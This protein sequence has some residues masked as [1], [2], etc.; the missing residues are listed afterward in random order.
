MDEGGGGGRGFKL[1]EREV[2]R[3]GVDRLGGGAGCGVG[4]PPQ[5]K[6]RSRLCVGLPPPPPAPL[7]GAPRPQ[8][9]DKR[10]F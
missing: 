1:P 4:D 8:G 5:G 2:E 3:W 9:C 7:Q 6:E 10:R